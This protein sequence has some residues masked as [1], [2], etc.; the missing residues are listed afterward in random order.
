MTEF[1]N[2]RGYEGLYMVTKTG[3]IWSNYTNK[4]LK[5][6]TD[7]DGYSIFSLC[8]QGTRKMGKVHRVVAQT[9]IDNPDNKPQVNHIDG[10]KTNNQVNNLE[11]CTC[12]E[13]QIHAYSIG[14]K[15]RK[16]ESHLLNK[17]NE[18][19]VLEIRRVYTTEKTSQYKLAEMYNVSQSTISEIITRNAWSHI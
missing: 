8:K 16:G 14:L 1:Y 7:K 13:N 12:S 5:L 10:D 17:L 9:F 18:E 19:D 11:W 4:F 3:K 15:N 2:I 6:T